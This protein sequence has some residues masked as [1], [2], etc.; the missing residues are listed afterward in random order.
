M[1][2]GELNP[3]VEFSKRRRR[4][5]QEPYGALLECIHSEK[6]SPQHD[7]NI[8]FNRVTSQ[9]EVIQ[10]SGLL[11]LVLIDWIINRTALGSSTTAIGEL[12]ALKV[13]HNNND[14]IVTF[15]TKFRELRVR[16][17]SKFSSS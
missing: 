13:G 4:A 5:D 6:S 17:D 2:T 8:L 9:K 7:A 12:L 1:K 10:R 16:L 14:G 3:L 11:A 15:L